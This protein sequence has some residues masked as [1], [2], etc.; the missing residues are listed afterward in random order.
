MLQ[1]ISD[2]S[3]AL[4]GEGKSSEPRA[5]GNIKNHSLEAL[6]YLRAARGVFVVIKFAMASYCSWG[7]TTRTFAV[8]GNGLNE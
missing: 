4:V 8:E 7:P 6:G 1:I 2:C 3:C 5:E